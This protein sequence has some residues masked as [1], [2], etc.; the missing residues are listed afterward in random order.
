MYADLC[1]ERKLEKGSGGVGAQP[2]RKFR[3]F[4]ALEQQFLRENHDGP[5]T[6]SKRLDEA[7]RSEV[8]LRYLVASRWGVRGSPVDRMFEAVPLPAMMM[9]FARCELGDKLYML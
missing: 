9:L 1:S 2:P 3:A 6:V 4:Q 8:L 7:N 5:H